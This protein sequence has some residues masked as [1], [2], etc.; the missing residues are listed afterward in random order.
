DNTLYDK[1][2]ISIKKAIR[3]DP[4]NAMAHKYY[5]DYH[6]VQGRN[7][8]A[9]SHYQIASELNPSKPDIRVSIGWHK[10]NLGDWEN[11]IKEVREGVAMSYRPPA[12]FHIPLAVDAFRQ[13]KFEESLKEAEIIYESGDKRGI[14]LSLAAAI[15]LNRPSLIKRYTK[16]YTDYRKDDLSEPF[17]EVS[18]VLKTPKVLK[19]YAETL[20]PIL[21]K[22]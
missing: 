12:Y 20:K 13:N 8:E 10:V 17:R 3:I 5:G 11:G 9:I 16:A 22:L 6:M 21:E 15:K 18:N 1:S 2:L 7:D 19:H 14:T 4:N